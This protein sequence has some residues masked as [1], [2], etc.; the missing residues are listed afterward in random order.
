MNCPFCKEKKS[1]H[2][3]FFCKEKPNFSKK[4]LRKI[5]LEYNYPDIA[6][7][8]NLIENYINKKKSLPDIRK[9]YGMDYSSTQFLLDMYNIPK[10]G[11]VDGSLNSMKKRENTNLEKYGSKNV[12]SKGAVGY[13]KKNKT[14]K[15]KYGVDNVFQIREVIEK[16]ND[17]GYYLKKY[18][19]TLSEYKSNNHIR[20]WGSLSEEEKSLFVERCNK[21][22]NETFNKNYGGHPSLDNRIKEN[23]RKSNK[24]KYGC[25]HFFQSKVFLEDE[26]IKEKSKETRIKNGYMISDVDMKPFL[27]YKRKCRKITYSQRKYLYENWDGY[28]YYD[29]EYIK[30]NLNLNNTNKNYPTI[31]HKISIFYGFLNNIKEEIIGNIEN[32]CITKRS[33][34]CSKRSKNYYTIKLESK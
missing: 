20:F 29:K 23:R 33:I 32:L 31:D 2:H 28:D 30:D 10:R 4:E 17:D 25:D 24:I 34:N 9:E 19:M 1:N 6:T 8:E 15:D 13:N 21:K 12:L 14:V 5:S 16:I 26:K 18:G 27:L 22:R 7:Y 11:L 3:L